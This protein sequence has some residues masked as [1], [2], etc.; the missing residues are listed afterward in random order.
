ML[1][2]GDPDGQLAKTVSPCHHHGRAGELARISHRAREG[3]SFSSTLEFVHFVGRR[4]FHVS[5][6]LSSLRFSQGRLLALESG[7]RMTAERD[8]RSG[9]K[10][11]HQECTS[12]GM[13]NEPP[14]PRPLSPKGARGELIRLPPLRAARPRAKGR[15][16]ASPYMPWRPW[17]AALRAPT[18][19][20]P[21]PVAQALMPV[22]SCRHS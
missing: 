11:L 5:N 15:G 21:T 3:R 10:D 18:R 13:V 19:G 4:W 2:S 9:G 16:G 14:H 20:A 8:G 22:R 12:S 17:A 7:L 1:Q 6:P